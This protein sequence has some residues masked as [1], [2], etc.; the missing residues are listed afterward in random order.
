MDSFFDSIRSTGLRRGPQRLL[1]G[2]LGGLADRLDVDV[3]FVR[4]IFIVLCFLPGPAVLAYLIA[5]TLI[6]DQSGAIILEKLLGGP[7]HGGGTPP[8]GAD[9]G[10]EAP[11]A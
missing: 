3:M 2:V 10:Q 5:W 9:P 7:R 6:P 11:T 1:G 4:V 8:A